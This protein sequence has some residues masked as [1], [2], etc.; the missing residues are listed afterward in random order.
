MSLQNLSCAVLRSAAQHIHAD[1][2]NELECLA[3][4]HEADL[5]L[6][7]IECSRGMGES[8]MDMLL[9]GAP[10][11]LMGEL[12]LY[13]GQQLLRRVFDRT[14]LGPRY[15]QLARAARA[16]VDASAAATLDRRVCDDREAA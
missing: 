13:L 10:A 9:S 5:M 4:E 15:D 14:D 1:S 6:S 2:V 16:F 11:E 3:I 8:F 12:H 7:D